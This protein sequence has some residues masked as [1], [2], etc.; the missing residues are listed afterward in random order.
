MM[1][2]GGDISGV[3]FILKYGPASNTVTRQP[4]EY[5]N[6]AG[7]RYIKIRRILVTDRTRT[8]LNAA[9]IIVGYT[10]RS[11]VH[12]FSSTKCFNNNVLT[13]PHFKTVFLFMID[14]FTCWRNLK[15]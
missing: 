5:V 8:H 13:S 14:I 6:E 10:I 4:G 15:I 2:Y 11:Q 3:A 1:I 7:D 12:K 9:K